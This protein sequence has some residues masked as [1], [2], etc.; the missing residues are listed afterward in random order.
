MAPL[1]KFFSPPKAV[2][3][4]L[5]L[6]SAGGL[7]YIFGND[8]DGRWF[9]YPVYCLSAYALTAACVWLVP[10]FIQMLRSQ[11]QRR[12]EFNPE[13]R[14]QRFRRS[15][16]MGM[17]IN[18]VYAVFNLIAGAVLESGWMGS[19]GL[20]YLVN[21]LI[22][23]IMLR[24]DRRLNANPDP[25]ARQRLGWTGF[26]ICGVLLFFLHLT[27][28]GIV[29]QMIWY[30]EVDTYPGFLIFAVA[31]YTFYKLTMAIIRVIRFRRNDHPIW[32]AAKNFDLSEAMMS[33]FSLQ[34]ALLAAFGEGFE[35]ELLMNSLTGGA[36]C[37]LAML[38]S[39]GMVFHGK[40][41]KLQL[42]G[43][44]THGSARFL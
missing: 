25:A 14:E 7:A 8:M 15:L 19:N 44:D 16:Y 33:L 35:S 1:R 3:V 24:Y 39:I 12:Q 2:T 17:G 11:K 10:V 30:G 31:A 43:E 27:M 42:Q 32:G 4:A 13:Q 26:Q 36:V 37:L 34:T 9:S 41:R 6:A 38:G 40:K 29:F 20:Y 18:L 28:T 5:V 23:F 22:H 21:T